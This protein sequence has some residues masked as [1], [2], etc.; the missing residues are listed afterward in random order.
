VSVTAIRKDWDDCSLAIEASWPASVERLWQLW[1]DPR[2]LERWWGP[3]GYPATVTTHELRPGGT[4][5]YAMTGPDGQQYPGWWTVEVVDAPY[6]LELVDGFADEDGMP[7][8]HLPRSRTTVT[9]AAGDDGTTRMVVT[10]RFSSTAEMDQLLD[11]GVEEG[12]VGAL[13]Q[14]DALLAEG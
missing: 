12:F 2:Q 3:P 5:R 6:R 9:F 10:S 11:M 14:I 7:D 4:V 8:D 13:N 1:A